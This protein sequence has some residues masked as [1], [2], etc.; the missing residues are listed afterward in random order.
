MQN[1]TQCMH[2]TR[3]Y[4][5]LPPTVPYISNSWVLLQKYQFQPQK[6]LESVPFWVT[7]IYHSLIG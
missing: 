2:L 5:S 1:N 4:I 3:S 6:L 7:M